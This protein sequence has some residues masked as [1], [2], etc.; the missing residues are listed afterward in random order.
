MALQLPANVLTVTPIYRMVHVDCLD[1]ILRR[2][3]LHAP[4]RV[5]NDGLPY[6][7]IHAQ[8]TQQDRGGKP[9]PC[10]PGGVIRDYVGFY[11]GPRSPMLLRLKT[12]RGVQ[13]VLQA[14]IVYLRTTAQ[15]IDGAKLRFVFTDRHTLAAVAAFRNKLADLTIVDFPTVYAEY[16]NDTAQL[17]YRQEKK[18]AE[19]LVH[20]KVPWSLVQVVGVLNDAAKER[21]EAILQNHAA[22][23]NPRVLRK[24]SWYY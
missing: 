7:S 15:A 4:T 12:G 3:A 21:V 10:P 2:N 16:W 20:R 13:R 14:D 17:P 1:T 19:F 6:V 5:P 24:P 11:L 22:R 8:Q 23:H 18:Q 9:V